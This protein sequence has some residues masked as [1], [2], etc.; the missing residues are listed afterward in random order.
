MKV[1]GSMRYNYFGDIAVLAVLNPITF[2]LK[3]QIVIANQ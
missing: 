3:S 2:C 1:T